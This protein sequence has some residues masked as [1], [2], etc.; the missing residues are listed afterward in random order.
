M[1]AGIIKTL[2]SFGDLY[3]AA[4]AQYAALAT[5]TIKI[6]INTNTVARQWRPIFV[7]LD[8]ERRG[9]TL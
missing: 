2:W 9:F 3:D 5:Q 4:M 6:P 8:T 1:Q 7:R